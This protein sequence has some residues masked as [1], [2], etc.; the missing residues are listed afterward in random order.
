M[1]VTRVLSNTL[2]VND[3]VLRPRN[4][5]GTTAPESF[6]W[7]QISAVVVGQSRVTVT[8]TDQDDGDDA[9]WLTTSYVLKQ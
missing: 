7:D 5:G 8:T 9:I 3:W 2:A 6:Y 1:A 4:N